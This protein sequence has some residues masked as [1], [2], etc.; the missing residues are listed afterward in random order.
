MTAKGETW[1]ESQRL[2]E[3]TAFRQES[4]ANP[5]PFAASPVRELYTAE[6]VMA[7]VVKV[8]AAIARD[9]SRRT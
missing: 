7:M 9:T 8:R 3:G 1:V 6:S 5:D 2:Q 4:G